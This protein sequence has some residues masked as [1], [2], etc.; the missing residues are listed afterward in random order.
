MK[1]L[2]GKGRLERC[3]AKVELGGLLR[4]VLGEFDFRKLDSR[5]AVN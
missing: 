5:I 4:F 2:S 3:S 1:H